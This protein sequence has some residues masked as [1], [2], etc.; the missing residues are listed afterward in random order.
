MRIK[1]NYGTV[2]T[3]TFNCNYETKMSNQRKPEQNLKIIC[4]IKNYENINY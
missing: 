3:L 1:N 4:H 2:N